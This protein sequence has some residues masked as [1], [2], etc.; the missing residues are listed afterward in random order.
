M[1]PRL[2]FIIAGGQIVGDFSMLYTTPERWAA[3]SQSQY[4]AQKSKPYQ[5]LRASMWA[6]PLSL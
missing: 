2:Q 6:S 5:R 4:A 3:S 1:D